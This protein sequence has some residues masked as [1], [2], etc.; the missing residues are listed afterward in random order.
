MDLETSFGR[1]LRARRR[2][3]DLT[4]DDLARRV[5]CSTVTIRKL[6]ADERRPSRQ[7]A[8]RLADGLK[9]MADERAAMITLARAEP[10]FDPPPPETSERPL[11]ILP[12]PPTNLP[13]P[14][15]RLI[16]RKQDIAA[17]RNALL[18][19]EARLLTLVG[20]PGIGKTRLSIA[21]AHDV[22]AAF[23]GGAYFVAL[24]PLG[25]P[26]L[27]LAT[28]A[29]TLGVR[30]T[31]GQPLLETLKSA[32]HARRLLLLLDNFEHLLDAAS[33]VVEL[34]E[35]CPG[36]KALVTSRAALHVR[37]ERL[38]ALPPLLLPDPTQP[39]AIVSLTRNPAVALLVE[40]AQAVM[41]DFRL[42]EQNAAAV[43]GI[44]VRLEGLPLAI[45]L[46]ATRVKLLHPTALLARL[47]QRLSLLT[48]GARD[49]PPRQR[50]LRAAIAW[51]YELLDE[52]EQMLF[53]RLGVFVGG[54]TL[55]AVAAVCNATNDLP[56]D[57]GGGI[58][59]LLDKSLLQ[60]VEGMDGE[61]RFTML[62]MIRE[63]ALE[64]LAAS[65]AEK[66][67]REQHAAFYLALA[68]AA[69][70]GQHGPS[71][72]MWFDRLEL[73][74]NNLRVALGWWTEH[75][76]HEQLGRAGYALWEFWDSKGHRSEG[77]EWLAP[78]L[79][80]G[81]PCLTLRPRLR[82]QVLLAAGWLAAW[83]GDAG[84]ARVLLEE[85]LALFQELDDNQGCAA[86]LDGLGRVALLQSEYAEAAARFRAAL[87]VGRA[88]GDR[89]RI[90]SSLN[91]LALEVDIQGDST[92]AWELAEESL[93]LF[94][95]LGMRQMCAE[96][97]GLLGLIANGRRDYAGATP[98]LEESLALARAAGAWQAVSTALNGL[99]QVAMAQ[100]DPQR[101]APLFAESLELR[102]EL[103]DRRGS[104]AMLTQLSE[105]MLECG[106]IA[107]AR[108]L[109]G[110]SF[111]LSHE[112]RYQQ[113][114]SWGLATA[115]E[116]AIAT[117]Q[118]ERAA[119]LLGAE[120]ALREARTIPIWGDLRRQYDRLSAA[121]H[122][123]LDDDAFA[124]AWAAGR[125][126]PL[127]QAITEALEW[128]AGSMS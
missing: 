37:G 46:A 115:A 3:L 55:D 120:E 32:L 29:Q 61:A 123:A 2:A 114:Y 121:A 30:E 89:F 40:C 104:I 9:I 91:W 20:P 98:L 31:A 24:A 57:V 62:E 23:A 64:R 78:A 7:I 69:S 12:Q 38:Y 63:Y 76:N 66:I 50:T 4:Q 126:L 99:G 44:C 125:A 28:I 56:V 124:A 128:S 10:N 117:G 26:A 112:I 21:V 47:E 102:R 80:T 113:G 14:L 72:D 49:L 83:Q 18:R 79:G 84:M 87:S 109:L 103:G 35:A 97:L 51:S 34:L 100:G 74:H 118:A 94:R 11:R 67:V 42:T 5:G 36:L 107:R 68:E 90:A 48:D 17:V 116:L 88:L 106:D 81:S 70:A 127:E 101:A 33:L 73:E 95:A 111:A 25:D 122:V 8:E 92:T 22:Q 105:A 6:E 27:V 53:A 54:C 65:G 13:A 96:V 45:E 75:G 58:A 77:R 1:W 60:Q 39:T 86:A 16:G 110:E 15:T 108:A 71:R 52:D 41:P 59:S 82:A 119:R 19:G 85:S 43:A 93:T